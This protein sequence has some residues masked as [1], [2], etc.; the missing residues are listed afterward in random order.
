MKKCDCYKVREETKYLTPFE[1]GIRFA[2][3]GE[4]ITKEKL[5]VAHC[6]GTKNCEECKCGGDRT[7]CDFYSG[8]REAAKQILKIKIAIHAMK[9]CEIEFENCVSDK[10][11]VTKF[12][13]SL[14]IIIDA[15]EKYVREKEDD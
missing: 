2:M 14:Q 10:E 13:E 12:L 6:W 15:A 1:Q 5:K 11:N 7:K 9:N 8:V 3:T 4:R